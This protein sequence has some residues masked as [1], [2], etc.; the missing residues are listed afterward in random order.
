MQAQ[1]ININWHWNELHDAF[2][3]TKKFVTIRAGRRSGK[4]YNAFQWLIEVLLDETSSA[5]WVDTVHPNID[6]YV[7]RYLFVGLPNAPAILK[8]IASFCHY[9]RQTK[10]LTLPNRSFIQFGSAEKPQN[11]E[12][13]EYPYIVLNEAGIILKKNALWDNT[14]E[15]MTKNSKAVRIIGTPKGK[16]KFHQLSHQNHPAFKDYQFS[17]YQSPYWDND[18]LKDIKERVPSTIWQQEYLAEFIEGAGSVFRNISNACDEN[19]RLY[20]PLGNGQYVMSADLAK[21]QDFTVIY[22]ADVNQKKVVYQERFNKID[23]VFQ[24]KRIVSLWQQWRCEAGIIDSTGIGDTIYDDLS[25]LGLNFEPFKFTSS[26]KNALVQNLSVSLDQA[27]IKFYPFPEL[28]NELEIFSYEVSPTGNVRYNAPDGFHD[29][30]VMSLA[31]LNKLLTETHNYE[32]LF[33]F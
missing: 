10:L 5:L 2:F 9:N 1:T 26:T 4:T 28:I 25:Q 16:N 31:M 22:I 8:N 15:P 17:P 21:H 7:D 11:L 18:M 32:E 3:S 33:N 24:K 6:A 20:E 13:F 14:I 19:C 12:G 29:D 30:C 23:W 27:K